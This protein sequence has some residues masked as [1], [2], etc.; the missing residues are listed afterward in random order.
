MKPLALVVVTAAVVFSGRAAIAECPSISRDDIVRLCNQAMGYSYYWGHAS[1]RSDGASHGSCSG[2]CPNC[3]H[4]GQYGADCSG[5]AGKVWQVP[6]ASAVTEDYH[7]YSTYNFRYETTHWTR[8]ARGGTMIRGDALVYNS[9]GSG[10]IMI[11]DSGDAWGTPKVWECKGCSYGCVH[12]SHSI[13]TSYIGIRRHNLATQPA[14]GKLQGTVY[15]DKGSGSDDMSQRLPGATVSTAGKTATARDGDAYWSFTLDAGGYTVSAAMSGYHSASRSCSVPEGGET[16]CSIGL[17]AVCTPSCAGKVCG[18]DGCGGSCGS[19]GADQ[20]CN[21]GKCECVMQCGSRECGPDPVCGASC[22]TC[23]D[24]TRCS[25]AG[26]CECVPACQGR[27]CGPDGCGGSCG[28]CPPGLLCDAS[29]LCQACVPECAG[30]V[31]GPDPLCG[32]SC[33]TCPAG[34]ACQD[35]QCLACVPDC[36]GRSCGPDPRCSMRCGVCAAEL[37]CDAAA[38]TCQ[39]IP[40]DRG[41]VF[42]TVRERRQGA[43]EQDEGPVVPRA[44]IR[45]DGQVQAAADEEGYFEF[46][47]G[48]GE[49]L[50]EAS[51]EKFSAGSV[52]CTIAG[53]AHADCSVLLDRL[54][55]D[56]E[57]EVVVL[58]GCGTGGGRSLSLLGLA[59]AG[60]L[61]ARR[62]RV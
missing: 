4:S 14:Q 21:A 51:A 25:A 39:T 5:L 10:H 7:P 9:N 52:T 12:G 48:P 62:R 61:M 46:S 45:L 29:G 1:W 56:P 31:C 41:K 3:T 2:S 26:V 36:A 8:V 30:R 60:L 34:Q 55:T 50:I 40:P 6:R 16:W 32:Q 58:G 38:G 59:L 53:G 33:G 18:P 47:V 27:E 20:A 57:D 35:G 37:L 13:S 11:Y 23:G 49:H 44:S 28:G 19:C 54:G 42:G 17:T 43:R 24:G 22:G 15:V